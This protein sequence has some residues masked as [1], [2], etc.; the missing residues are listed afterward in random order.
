MSNKQ[1][2]TSNFE[3]IYLDNKYN[4]DICNDDQVCNKLLIRELYQL[5]LY[6]KLKKKLLDITTEYINKNNIPVSNTDIIT[7]SSEYFNQNIIIEVLIIIIMNFDKKDEPLFYSRSPF[8]KKLID[9]YI[10]DKCITMNKISMD[11]IINVLPKLSDFYLD[12]Y[13]DFQNIKNKILDIKYDINYVIT[14]NFVNIDLNI[15]NEYITR[16]N[17]DEIKYKNSIKLSLHIFNH[18]IKLYN[19]KIL[20]DYLS[21]EV[22][23][24]IVIEYIYMVYMRYYIISSGNMQASILPSFKKLLKDRLNIKIE[25]FGSPLNTSMTNFG[26]IFYDIEWVF[27]SFG[28]YF[29]TNIQKGYYEA[30]PPFDICLIK[31]MFDKMIRELDK[32]EN[33]KLPL[34][35]FIIFPL[36]YSKTNKIPDLL[37]PYI[38]FDKVFN[39]NDFTYIRYDRDFIKTNVSSITDTHILICHTSFINPIYTSTVQNFNNIFKKWSSGTI[40]NPNK[41]AKIDDKTAKIDD[42]TY[43]FIKSYRILN[44]KL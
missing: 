6:N 33:N 26:S 38:K 28:N 32:A 5:N 20:N 3:L 23:D 9:K 13:D 8:D 40:K 12:C 29:N 4:Y 42:K 44:K 10:K 37:Q 35:F 1:I 14:D 41:S 17:I 2:K 19:T 22:K 39:K 21:I 24:K 18:L 31:N 7:T 15:D 27:G 36:S 25:L 30:N 16:L 11:V 34:L 43:N